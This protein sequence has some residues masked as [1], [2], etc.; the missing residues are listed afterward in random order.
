MVSPTEFYQTVGFHFAV[1]FDS[2]GLGAIDARF[3]SVSGLNAQIETETLKEGGENRFTHVLPA[4]RKFSDLTLKRGLLS[5][6]AG[7]K[8]TEWCLNTFQKFDQK[9]ANAPKRLFIKPVN[10]DIV[11]LNEE[12]QPL[13]KWKVIHAW[14]K[15]WKFGDL[16]AE[17]SEVLIET[18]ELHYNYFEFSNP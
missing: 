15:A 13:M 1:S 8:I 2:L 17:K 18:L 5:P 11:L 12:H 14:P 7:S 16:H 9:E 4:R 10:L 3:Q 6:K